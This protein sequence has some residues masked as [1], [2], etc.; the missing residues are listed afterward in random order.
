LVQLADGP[1]DLGRLTNPLTFR[2]CLI[3]F[4]PERIRFGRVGIPTQVIG[5][6]GWFTFCEIVGD[7]HP[8]RLMG[9]STPSTVRS[10]SLEGSI[11]IF[12]LSGEFITSSEII[13]LA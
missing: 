10:L 6:S 13:A 11:D 7:K 3:T 4:P 1:G 9:P 2:A 8:V 12:E 5:T